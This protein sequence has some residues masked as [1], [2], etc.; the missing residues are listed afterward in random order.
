MQFLTKVLGRTVFDSIGEPIGKVRDVI[1]TPAEPLPYVSAIVVKN[2]DH[3]SI[4]PWN[5]I[6]E[7]VDRLSLPVRKGKELSYTPTPDDIWLRK[8]VLDRQIV[9][10][11]DYKLVRVNDVRFVETPGKVC[12]LGVDASTR[13]LLRELGIEWLA[14]LVEIITRKPV[15]EKIIMWNDVETL[16][17]SSGPI[18]LKIPLQKLSRLHPADIA[19]II[20][21]MNPLQRTDVIES[22]DVEMAADVLPEASPEIQAMIIE[23]L[24]PEM[25]SDI[26]EEMEPDEAADILRDLPEEHKEKLL[27]KME[28]EEADDVRELLDYEDETAGGLMT[29]NFVSIPD[30]LTADGA[31]KYLRSLKPD[32]ESI[33]YV[34]VV[35]ETKRIEGVLSLRDLIVAE[36]DTPIEDIMIKRVVHVHPDASLREVAELFQKYNL[37]ALPVVDFDNELKGIITVDDMLENVPIHI[38]K[39]KPG[40]RQSASEQSLD[41]KKTA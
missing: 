24:D 40:K 14:S 10:V 1:V 16:E 13:G 27:H 35:S 19:D 23:D 41:H 28:Q 5:Q 38:W 7:E 36:P 21:Q 3:E 26:L 11:Q 20:E 37:L 22:L 34:Y 9:D 33:Y 8:Q 30:S 32:A 6:R 17:K 18:K 12:L 15:P 25:A 4:I 39:G 2:H 31:I 29:T